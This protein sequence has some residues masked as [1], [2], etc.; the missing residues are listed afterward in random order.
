MKKTILILAAFA[1][2][3]ILS[4]GSSDAARDRFVEKR[5]F[6]SEGSIIE[7]ARTSMPLAR[8]LAHYTMGI[9]YDNE[10]KTK[11]ALAEYKK[12]LE[13]AP[14]ISYIHTRLAADYLLTKDNKN[15]LEELG[16]AK[17]LD[18]EDARPRFLLA[19]V[20]AS[21]DRFED[22]RKEY[23]DIIRFNPESASSSGFLVYIYI[24]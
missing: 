10:L 5:A 12:A 21:L 22:A 18:P 2:L 16:T 8:S 20:Y 9:I 6:F 15:A 4:P 19:L 17:A 7:K 13:I 11:E 3:V 24:L 23:G 14:E 1:A